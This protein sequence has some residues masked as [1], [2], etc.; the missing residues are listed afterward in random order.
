[1]EKP[2]FKITKEINSSEDVS[3]V[4]ERDEIDTEDLS[5][6]SS[7][8]GLI[9]KN[10][11]IAKLEPDMFETKSASVDKIKYKT[12]DALAHIAK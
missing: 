3:P 4:I 5:R 9:G 2:I 12:S 8:F 7:E 1:M 10:I 11:Y 6:F